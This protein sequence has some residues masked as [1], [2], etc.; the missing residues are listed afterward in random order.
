MRYVF[1]V[2]YVLCSLSAFAGATSTTLDTCCGMVEGAPPVWIKK[3]QV[4][5]VCDKLER[6]L[7]W[8]IR[9]I[10]I[11]WFSSKDAF[12]NEH[13]ISGTVLAFARASENAVYVGPEVEAETFSFVFGHELAH[14]ILF[15]KYK[16]AV[17]KWLEEGLANFFSRDLRYD[18]SGT[19]DYAWLATQKL[20][21]DVR[22]LAHPFKGLAGPRLHYTVST[23]LMEMI[24]K[25]CNIHQLLQLSVAHGLESY[26]ATYC[27]IADVNRS[28]REWVGKKG[29]SKLK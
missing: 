17:P 29:Q 21:D 19:V 20:P 14:V 23:A 27:G 4:E 16:G 3:R 10:R 8:D 28:F 11:R 13:K 6:A 9:R 5:K 12:F 24:A 15:Q 7:E 18:K 22:S 25:K 26:L 2:V 1:T